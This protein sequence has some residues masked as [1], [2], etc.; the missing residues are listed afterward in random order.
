MKKLWGTTVLVFL[1]AVLAGEAADNMKAF[2]PPEKGDGPIL[3]W[4]FLNRRTNR[5]LK[6]N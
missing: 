6:W 1:F 4:N 3:S 2:P 5:L